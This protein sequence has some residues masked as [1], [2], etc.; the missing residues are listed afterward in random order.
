MVAITPGV[1]TITNL[2]VLHAA[3]AAVAPISGVRADGTIMFLPSATPAQIAAANAAVAAF[4]DQPSPHQPNPL[5]A[6]L[7]QAVKT[8]GSVTAAQ[9]NAAL[10]AMGQ[11]VTPPAVT[12][13]PP[14]Q[15]PLL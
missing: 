2:A 3:V 15:G 12:L 7:I 9:I 8:P 5:E 6:L 14:Y 1:S 11:P 13:A 10:A 4:V